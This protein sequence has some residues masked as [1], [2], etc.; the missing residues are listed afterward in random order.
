[1]R[2]DHSADKTKINLPAAGRSDAPGRPWHRDDL[3]K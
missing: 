1:M 3:L 2:V